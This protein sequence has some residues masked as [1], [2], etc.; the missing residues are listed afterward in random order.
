MKKAMLNWVGKVTDAV[1][2][3]PV[4][5][6]AYGVACFVLGSLIGGMF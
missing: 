2:T 3:Q 4:T 5:L 1:K 6:G